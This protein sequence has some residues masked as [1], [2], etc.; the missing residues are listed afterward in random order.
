M[1]FVLFLTA[2]PALEVPFASVWP[3]F[4]A[5]V[6]GERG[7]MP[8]VLV[9]TAHPALEVPFA[10]VWPMFRACVR[11]EKGDMPFV[12]VYTA[13]PALE[14]L[15]ASVWPMFGA[16]AVRFR[17]WLPGNQERGVDLVGWDIKELRGLARERG[18]L[19]T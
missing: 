18:T 2:H 5:C 16:G 7:D 12:L 8:F 19:L 15:F 13:H 14:V 17:G 6:R 10:S 3:M 11:G 1:P 9:F 4:R